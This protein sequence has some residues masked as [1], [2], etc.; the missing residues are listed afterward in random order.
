MFSTFIYGVFLI[1][2]VS[3][4]GG[5][6]WFTWHALEFDRGSLIVPLTVAW[7]V[8]VFR[9][10]T[11]L[12]QVLRR[13]GEGAEVHWVQNVMVGTVI[14]CGVLIHGV[15]T[16]TW[17]SE[18]LFYRGLFWFAYALEFDRGSLIVPLTVAW[19]VVFLLRVRLSQIVRLIGAWVKVNWA[20][21]VM[22][23]TVICGGLFLDVGAS[24]VDKV[25]FG[26]FGLG[27]GMALWV[28]KL[29]RICQQCGCVSW[30]VK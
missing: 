24:V 10:R 22:V 14:L 6:F 15:S 12:S 7:W 18:G 13:I 29:P 1:L 5:L 28:Y 26:M 20:L 30:G 3:T 19:W 17:F 25:Y 23:G 9:W 2:G 11:R 21:T 4:L 16:V 8:V 27:F